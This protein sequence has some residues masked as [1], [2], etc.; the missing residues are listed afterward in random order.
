MAI[1]GLLASGGRVA[2]GSIL[3][4]GED[5]THF[6]EARMR[7]V[8]GRQIGL[9][10]QDPMSHLNPVAKIG[11]QVAETLLAPGLAPPSDVQHKVVA[12]LER[13]CL[14]AAASRPTPA[15]T[16]F[17]GRRR[18]PAAPPRQPSQQ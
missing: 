7:E 17:S 5:L 12:A 18:H 1:I 3:L 4:D 15:P 2:R 6:S 13:A 10:P 16:A 11:T 14:P 9:V 8:R